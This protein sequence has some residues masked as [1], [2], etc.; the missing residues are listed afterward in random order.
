MAARAS[1]LIIDDSERFLQ[2]P[3][4]LLLKILAN[5]RFQMAD[6]HKFFNFV[7]K[8]INNH[9]F[10]KLTSLLTRIKAEDFSDHEVELIL[11]SDI[12]DLTSIARLIA[13]IAVRLL[14]AGR[15]TRSRI[16]KLEEQHRTL[17]HQL[18]Q[19][20]KQAQSLRRQLNEEKDTHR[21]AQEDLNNLLSQSEEHQARRTTPKKRE[22]KQK[23]KHQP[24]P[25]SAASPVVAIV[26]A[27]I[28]QPALSEE[29]L[30]TVPP[31]PRAV[32][33]VSL[34]Q[35]KV[36]K[37][38]TKL[39]MLDATQRAM[40]DAARVNAPFVRVDRSAKMMPL[41]IERRVKTEV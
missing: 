34:P 36:E 17:S 4:N 22:R 12:L 9:Q 8:A 33:T 16:A 32:E 7:I 40:L 21:R 41:Q 23:P 35:I 24:R 6:S 19:K 31:V 39:F 30:R 2:I 14:N 13:G 1:T 25:H 11:E 20:T 15:H 3:P 29:P 26:P 28:V 18:D 38:K 10:P 37:P 27:G 5:A